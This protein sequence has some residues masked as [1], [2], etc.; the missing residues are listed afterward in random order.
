MQ[1]YWK[2]GRSEGLKATEDG[3]KEILKGVYPGR[4]LIGIDAENVNLWGGGLHCIT[5]HMPAN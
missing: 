3:V 1:V 5:Q 2:T 4:T